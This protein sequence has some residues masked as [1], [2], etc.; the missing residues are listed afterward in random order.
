MKKLAILLALAMP[1]TAWALSSI[2]DTWPGIGQNRQLDGLRCYA[3]AFAPADQQRATYVCQNGQCTAR[4]TFPW[5]GGHGT[6]RSSAPAGFTQAVIVNAGG[7]AMTNMY[8]EGN[9][10]VVYVGLLSGAPS[11]CA[12]SRVAPV[13]LVAKWAGSI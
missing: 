5:L 6:L 8:F 7:Q 12:F 1:G 9:G 13:G 4:V 3:L 10:S 2:V 11:W